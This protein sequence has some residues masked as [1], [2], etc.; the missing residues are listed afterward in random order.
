[1]IQRLLETQRLILQ[2]VEAGEAAELH[3]IFAQEGVYRYL[4]DGVSMPLTWV[5]GIIRDSE[6]AFEARGLGLWS[7]REHRAQPIIGLTGF[8][9]FYDPPVLELLYALLP[10]YWHRGLATEMAEAAVAYAF[11]HRY[12][13]EIRASTD[14]PNHASARVMARLGMRPHGRTAVGEADDICWDQLH[15]ILSYEDWCAER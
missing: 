7:V 9:E 8:R 5:E 6:A 4:T 14:E 11:N 3:A 12:L 15:F 1:M 13:S 10:A 2:P